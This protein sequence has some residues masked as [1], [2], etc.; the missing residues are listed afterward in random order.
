MKHAVLLS[1][2]RVHRSSKKS[3]PRR[4]S[5]KC[6]HE[7]D[8]LQEEKQCWECSLLVGVGR[9]CA[10]ASA[11][12]WIMK[13]IRGSLRKWWGTSPTTKGTKLAQVAMSWHLR[14]TKKLKLQVAERNT[15]LATACTGSN[16]LLRY[17]EIKWCTVHNLCTSSNWA[18]QSLCMETH[19]D[20]HPQFLIFTGILHGFKQEPH[21]GLTEVHAF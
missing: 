1:D 10:E 2:I 17:N 7:E 21:K 12:P 19:E 4:L 11:G 20:L 16:K 15:V 18:S 5:R 6:S 8:R 9:R 14:N 3:L 13:H